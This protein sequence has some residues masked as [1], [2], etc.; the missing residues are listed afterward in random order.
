MTGQPD[1]HVRYMSGSGAQLYG[2]LDMVTE[3][4]LLACSRV[5][6][7]IVLADDSG[8]Q[9]VQ[10]RPSDDNNGKNR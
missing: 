1:R 6:T 10:V 3:V 9:H 5:N 8:P 4:G 2:V 7:A